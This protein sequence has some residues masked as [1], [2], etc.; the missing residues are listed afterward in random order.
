MY[1]LHQFLSCK[2]G[3]T[4]VIST[5]SIYP[6]ENKFKVNLSYT[7]KMFLKKYGATLADRS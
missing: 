6:A 2:Q 4:K 5:V 1:N 7:E 3:Q